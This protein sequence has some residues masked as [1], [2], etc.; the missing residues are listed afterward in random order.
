M[1]I[2]RTALLVA[3]VVGVS[4]SALAKADAPLID[5][6]RSGDVSVVRALLDQGADVEGAAAD[7]ST[8]LQW[9]VHEGRASLV[10]L[11]LGAGADVTASGTH[12][13]SL[14]RCS[15]LPAVGF[16]MKTKFTVGFP[17]NPSNLL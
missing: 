14:P 15:V 8:A 12:S 5:A 4:V 16:P 6:V 1:R 2:L 13:P 9:A 17:Q 10:E 3:L 11:L 7:G